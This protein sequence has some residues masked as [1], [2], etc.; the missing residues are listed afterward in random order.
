MFGVPQR[1][2]RLTGSYTRKE[3]FSEAEF[4]KFMSP[5]HATKGAKIYTKYGILKYQ[6]AFSAA[7][8]RAVGTSLKLPWSIDEHDVIIEYYYKD[9]EQMLAISGD[10][11]FKAMHV[12]CEPYINMDNTVISI[13]WVEVFIEDG[14]LANINSAGET[15]HAPFEVSFVMSVAERPA[16]KYY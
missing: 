3:G 2:L 10:N 16:D 14:K 13:T 5:Q 9:I 1:V 4:H 12:E 15:V 11:D 7:S 8:T 6:L